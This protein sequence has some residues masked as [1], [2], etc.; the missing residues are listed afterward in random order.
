MLDSILGN[1]NTTAT[2]FRRMAHHDIYSRWNREQV[3]TRRFS[4][5]GNQHIFGLAFSCLRG[6]HT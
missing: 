6:M 2:P 3:R 1:R 4:Y 5:E